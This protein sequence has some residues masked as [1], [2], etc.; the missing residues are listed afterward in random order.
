MCTSKNPLKY[1]K[2]PYEVKSKY[3]EKVTLI[4]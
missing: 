1:N 4:T 3:W 2:K